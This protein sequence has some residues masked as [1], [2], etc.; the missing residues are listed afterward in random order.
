MHGVVESKDHLRVSLAVSLNRLFE[1]RFKICLVIA[2]HY[3]DTVKLIDSL[4]LL[5]DLIIA[6]VCCHRLES[7][8]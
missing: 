8:V 5:E 7:L 6:Q 4:K 1:F 2:T 3:T